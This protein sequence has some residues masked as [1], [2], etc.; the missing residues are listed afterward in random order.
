MHLGLDVGTGRTKLAR[1]QDEAPLALRTLVVPTAISY[2]GLASTI[3]APVPSREPPADV[4]RCDGFPAMLGMRPP[5]RVTAWA[6]A[7]PSR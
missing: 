7:R 3:A 4:V 6:A 1:Y 2:H 5:D